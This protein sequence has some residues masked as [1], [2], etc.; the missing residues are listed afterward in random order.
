MHKPKSL[1]SVLLTLVLALL[2][3]AYPFLVYHYVSDVNPRWF[4]LVLITLYA[5][6]FGLSPST[7]STQDWLMLMIVSAFCSCIFLLQSQTLL[8]F[9][10][11]LM[12]IGVGSAFFVSLT[13]EQCLIDKFARMGGK[14]PPPEAH[15]YLRRLTLIWGILLFVNGAVS[16]FTA[17]YTSLATWTLYNGLLSYLFMACFALFEWL[18]RGYYKKTRNIVDE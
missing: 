16:A 6:K 11:V 10:P 4:A 13:G 17:W 8:K 2:A 7:K 15:T 12:S 1:L 5:I 18:Y 14:P 9:Y 3:V